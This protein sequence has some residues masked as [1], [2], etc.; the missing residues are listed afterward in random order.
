MSKKCTLSEIDDYYDCYCY[1]KRQTLD[2]VVVV[3]D[4]GDVAVVVA[5]MVAHEKATYLRWLY[6]L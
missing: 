2:V 1:K 4:G 3:G 5:K 6:D